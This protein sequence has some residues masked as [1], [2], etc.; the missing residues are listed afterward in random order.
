MLVSPAMPKYIYCI[1]D[2]TL[3]Y[4]ASTNIAPTQMEAKCRRVRRYRVT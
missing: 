2:A 1:Y 4:S 3:Y